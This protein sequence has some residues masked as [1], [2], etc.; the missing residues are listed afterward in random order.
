M[1]AEAWSI[2][3]LLNVAALGVLYFCVLASFLLVGTTTKSERAHLGERLVGWCRR[4]DAE[5]GSLTNEDGSVGPW[6]R[7]RLRSGPEF[8]IV[9]AAHHRVKTVLIFVGL[10][11]FLIGI[12][13]VLAMVAV[14]VVVDAARPAA[15]SV[16]LGS[17]SVLAYFSV[18]AYVDITWRSRLSLAWIVLDQGLIVERRASRCSAGA[19]AADRVRSSV[20]DMHRRILDHFISSREALVRVNWETSGVAGLAGLID[21]SHGRQLLQRSQRQIWLDCAAALTPVGDEHPSTV[22]SDGSASPVVASLLSVTR[23]EA[24]RGRLAAGLM[25]LMA[26]SA[27][28]CLTAAAWSFFQ[29]ND[30]DDIGQAFVTAMDGAQEPVTVVVGV[31][32]VV[33]LVVKMVRTAR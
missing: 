24:R 1:W 16:L 20:D 25:P 10:G 3:L 32:T 12:I 14:T 8:L 11:V 33:G 22:S 27:L 17:L 19:S 23:A 18:L 4:N 13:Q 9:K 26:G 30:A 2:A 15:W 7:L 31:V 6:G 21:N 29:S 5:L 28:L